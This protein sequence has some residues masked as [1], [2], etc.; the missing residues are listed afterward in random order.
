MQNNGTHWTGSLTR[1]KHE[2][3]LAKFR[4]TAAASTNGGH[5]VSVFGTRRSAVRW[6]S[7][8]TAGHES[9]MEC[10]SPRW[11]RRE[12]PKRAKG[13]PPKPTRM[14]KGTG[15]NTD[16]DR[17]MAETLAA[18]LLLLICTRRTR[19]NVLGS[20]RFSRIPLQS[21]RVASECSPTNLLVVLALLLQEELFVARPGAALHCRHR[22]C[23]H[24]G[25]QW[26]LVSASP[27]TYTDACGSPVP[28]KWP[29]TRC[30][31]VIQFLK[32]NTGVSSSFNFDMRL[33]KRFFSQLRNDCSMLSRGESFGHLVV[34][35][36]TAR[37]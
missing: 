24:N 23:C 11:C 36:S 3:S 26:R 12:L 7:I 8:W 30:I 15:T 17:R 10:R 16:T 21:E 29:Y 1:G 31:P 28:L 27:Q 37:A 9:R 25:P 18:L 2:K 6:P 19:L 33:L 34:R 5:G 35:S 22:C 4:S 14:S 32:P 13:G 20:N